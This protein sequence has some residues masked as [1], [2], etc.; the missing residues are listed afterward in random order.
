M[1]EFVGA[2][3]TIGLIGVAGEDGSD[4]SDDSDGFGRGQTAAAFHGR[5]IIAR[6]PGLSIKSF[7]LTST[8]LK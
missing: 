2:G 5:L 3:S 4:K 8:A 6:H 7:I 1:V